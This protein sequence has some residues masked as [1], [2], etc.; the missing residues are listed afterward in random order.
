MNLFLLIFFTIGLA[1]TILTIAAILR[2]YYDFVRYSLE[3]IYLLAIGEATITFHANSI[4]D[5]ID[6]VVQELLDEA[7][8]KKDE[9]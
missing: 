5:I 8:S 1:S 7:E 2:G 3:T 9:E 4:D 6:E